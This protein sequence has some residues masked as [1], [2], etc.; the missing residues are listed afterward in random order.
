M[1]EGD[2]AVGQALEALGY[3]QAYAL[4]LARHPYPMSQT[5]YY[6]AGVMGMEAP[7]TFQNK[8]VG[9]VALGIA[10]TPLT[11]VARLSITLKLQ[12]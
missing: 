5:I 7:I 4:D 3:Q 10:E 6:A 2:D 12:P 8:Q 11:E 1:L 9:R